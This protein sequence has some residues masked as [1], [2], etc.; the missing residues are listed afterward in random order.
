M[1]NGPYRSPV[2]YA[3]NA[4]LAASDSIRS[5]ASD[6]RGPLTSPIRRNVSSATGSQ[7][8]SG[9]TIW[10]RWRSRYTKSRDQTLMTIGAATFSSL[11]SSVSDI[12]AG[13][14]AQKQ[15]A[16]QAEGL[17]IQAEGTDISAKRWRTA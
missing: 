17:D 12:F 6:R 15:G 14:G 10:A 7:S 13:I 4:F 1:T 8:C 2:V 16:L 11:G 5:A 9:C 3:A